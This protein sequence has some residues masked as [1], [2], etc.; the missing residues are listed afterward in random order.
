MMPVD[1]LTIAHTSDLGALVRPLVDNWPLIAAAAG[2]IW[3][4]SGLSHSVQSMAKSVSEIT[5][6][7]DKRLDSH[8]ETIDE[9]NVRVSRLEGARGTQHDPSAP[10]HS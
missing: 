1:T 10:L 6:R 7:F 4:L 9:I 8:S 5:E 2:I 3:H